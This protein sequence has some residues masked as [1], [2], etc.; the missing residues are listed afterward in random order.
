MNATPEAAKVML[1]VIKTTNNTKVDTGFKAAGGGVRDVVDAQ[2]YLDLA[3]TILGDNWVTST[4]FRLVQVVYL[5]IYFQHLNLSKALKQALRNIIKRG[6]NYGTTLF[7]LFFNERYQAL[8]R[9]H[10]KEY[11]PPSLF[12]L[13]N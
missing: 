13:L 4:H 11:V 2:V 8:C 3:T 9:L 6:Y 10:F 12:N 7:L 5:I 1:E